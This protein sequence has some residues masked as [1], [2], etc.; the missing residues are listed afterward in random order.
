M[1]NVRFF[2]AYIVPRIDVLVSATFQSSPG[3]LVAALNRQDGHHAWARAAMAELPPP[4]ATCEAVLAE[5]T[6]LLRHIPNGR[7]NVVALLSRRHVTIRFRLSDEADA[8]GRLL[9]RYASVPM[10]LADACLVRMAELDPE[11][12]V[13]TLDSDFHIYRKHG[14][15]AI[16]TIT[17]SAP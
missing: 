13:L 8:V 9:A 5:A 3:P 16:K 12:T 15:Q 17:P 10:S 4:L 6:F 2:G 7:E 14:R 11:I 1:T